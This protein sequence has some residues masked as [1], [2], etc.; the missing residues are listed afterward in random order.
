MAIALKVYYDKQIKCKNISF[1][2]DPYE[3]TNPDGP[4][5]RKITYPDKL[6]SKN[7]LKLLF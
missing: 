1:S 5:M 2:L 4:Y 7:L 3:E 6:E